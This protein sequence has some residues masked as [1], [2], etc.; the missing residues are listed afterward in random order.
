M[1]LI[2]KCQTLMPFLWKNRSNFKVELKKGKKILIKNQ[3]LSFLF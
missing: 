1:F 3:V 2:V